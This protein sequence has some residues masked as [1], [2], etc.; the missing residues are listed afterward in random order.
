MGFSLR[1]AVRDV[2]GGD[3]EKMTDDE[4]A[5]KIEEIR[6]RPRTGP[7]FDLEAVTPEKSEEIPRGMAPK[8]MAAEFGVYHL[9]WELA[10]GCA[11]PGCQHMAGAVYDFR[12]AAMVDERRHR[13]CRCRWVPLDVLRG[14]QKR[15]CLLP[16][17]DTRQR[18]DLL[19]RIYE[20]EKMFPG[21][22]NGGI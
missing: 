10:D 22:E 19:T 5:E 11:C 3:L 4:L 21:A 7:A 14:R 16:D 6:S 15:E 1:D 18:G 13:G 2:L 8:D 12:L 20:A 9:R 17:A